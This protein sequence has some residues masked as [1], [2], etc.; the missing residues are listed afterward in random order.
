MLQLSSDPNFHFELLRSMAMTPYEGADIGEV[1]IAAPTIAA[2]DFKS[3]YTAFHGLA[4]RTEKKARAIDA[5][6]HPV[7]ARNMFFKASTY[8]ASTDFYLHGN[9]SDPR[10]Y[11]LWDKHLQTFDQGMK[12]MKMPGKRITIPTK[13]GFSVP[14][15]FFSTG[16]PG[17]RPTLI[18]GNGFDGS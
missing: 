18:I 1:L 6:R 12:L 4:A 17:R 9:Q 7:S 11:S 2:G 16:L 5:K 3:Y 15:I 8:Y 13:S 14:A 10:I